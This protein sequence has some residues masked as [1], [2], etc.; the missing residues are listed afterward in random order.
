MAESDPEV[1]MIGKILLEFLSKNSE[2]ILSSRANILLTFARMVLISPLC[3]IKR[4]GWA[5]CQDGVV[6]V[7]KRECTI[8][9]ADL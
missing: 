5:L 3:A 1:L 2:C 8:A 4:F 6:F 7:E 9:M